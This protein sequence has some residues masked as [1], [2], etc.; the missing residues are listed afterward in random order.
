MK[1]CFLSALFAFFAAAT[2]VAQP[3]ELKQF[4]LENGLTVFLWED[5]NQS[6]VLGQIVVRAGSMDE[7]S[8][9]TGLAHYL[10]HVLFKGTQKIG[11]LDWEKEKPH[12]EK[13]I[14]LYD[15]LAETVEPE[16][17][18]TL[19]TAINEE[20]LTA[21]QYGSTNELSN[22][23]EGIGGTGL[24]AG[25]S[26]DMTVYY[27][28]FPA[29]QMERWLDIY[30][31][32]FINPVFRTF[33]AELE[34]VYEEFN[35]Y[36]DDRSTHVRNY[37]FSNIYPNHPY[38]RDI[39]GTQEHLKNPRLSKLIDFYN[40]WYVPNNMALVL[41]GNFKSEEI[42]PLI[43]EKFS[44][45]EAKELPARA[46]YPLP[47]YNYQKFTERLGYYP[48][49]YWAFKGVKKGDKDELLLNFCSNIL[50]NSSGTGLLDR[51]AID[52]DVMAAGA[53]NMPRRDQGTMLI[54]AIPSYDI[55][56]Q[57]YASDKE[58]QRVVF[59]EVRKLAE[60]NIPD[61][62]ITSVKESLCKEFDLT[63]ESSN[64]IANLISEAFVYDENINNIFNYKEAVM[65]ITKEDIQRIAKQYFN[66]EN[67]LLFSFMDGSPKRTKLQK[68]K[69]KPIEQPQTQESAY[70]KA[71]KE[72]PMGK[73]EEKFNDFNSI[74]TANLDEKTK[75][76]Y[77]KNPK[78]DIF[79][80]VI[81]YGVGTAKMPKLELATQLLN[82]A[83]IMPSTTPQD[84]KRMF[85]EANATCSYSCD[86]SYFYISIVGNESKLAE[87][88]QIMQKQIYMPKLE[89][90]Q[91]DNA[92]GSIISMRMTETKNPDALEDALLEYLL[93]NEKS[94]YLDRIPAM[95]IYN[96]PL[97]ELTGEIIRAAQYPAEVHYAGRLPIETVTETLKAN[98][99]LN[100]SANTSTSPEVREIA[101]YTEP[102]IYL[103][104]NSDTQQ[105]KIYFYIHG[106]DYNCADDVDYN[107]FYQ[108]FSGGFSGLVMSEIREN[109]SMAYTTYGYIS[110]PPVPEK[111][112]YFLGFVGTQADKT[113]D[114]VKLYMKL[115][116]DM[117]LY[118][119]RIDNIKTYLRES[120]LTSKP[121]FRSASM[122]FEAMKLRGYT[123]D[124][125]KV[126]LGKVDSL[127]FAD[128]ERFYNENIKGKPI[129]IVIMGNTKEIDKKALKAIGK[130]KNISAGRLFQ[131]VEFY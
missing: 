100:E 83:G 125:A 90:K 8:D 95:D 15:E 89:M 121:S 114:A 72:I 20:S 23:I 98:L 56:Q 1:K 92:K 63:M 115:L 47:N 65:A 54:I 40:T 104:P 130:V 102:V 103:L 112:T 88:C 3:A 16:A 80:L 43:K 58:T 79:S 119:E 129:S 91:L 122:A 113:V 18:Q 86:D 76:F 38:G 75:L 27:N 109:N 7:P 28:T 29:Y 24:N 67:Y 87:A 84:V 14:A 64:A 17:R 19:I 111:P 55:N 25:T 108:Y 31:E 124:P 13:I 101:N 26:Y 51:L 30:S 39:I 93:Y 34:N 49:M 110:R 96:M 68:P 126:N 81:Q 11:A 127:T 41:S 33:Q 9:Y 118:P 97:A 120:M 99:P 123:D 94:D 82:N 71:F 48:Q 77:N 106:K 52:G 131:P 50:T 42:I 117:P 35:M 73:S 53:T 70:A 69:I 85:S 37:M 60:G 5:P 4:K 66:T 6:S 116:T 22:L 44:R 74:Q 78:N 59:N 57:R 128:I 107:A 36:Q 10:E 105:S 45:L 46:Q 32:R 21:A 2:I 61:W 12:Y 62:L